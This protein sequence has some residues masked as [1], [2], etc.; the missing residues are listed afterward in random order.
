MTTILTMP[1]LLSRLA[2]ANGFH[3]SFHSSHSS[4]D[5][6]AAMDQAPVNSANTH[7]AALQSAG[8]PV[9]DVDAY[10]NDPKNQALL[11]STSK[12]KKAV[13]AQ[14]SSSGNEPVLLGGP[15]TSHH[16]KTLYDICN[17]KGLQPEFE[18]EGDEQGFSGWVSINGETIGTD[19]RWPN[20]KAVKEALAERAIPL[21]KSMPVLAVKPAPAAESKVN[22]IGKLLGK[23]DTIAISICKV[24][25]RCLYCGPLG[26]VS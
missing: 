17:P 16:I 20:K 26:R 21:A 24:K 3:E 7:I 6:A 11:A 10:L 9:Y 15:R 19:E 4:P 14:S 18:F 23:T 22:W 2:A 8:L 25:R 5:A 1:D 13:A 12:S